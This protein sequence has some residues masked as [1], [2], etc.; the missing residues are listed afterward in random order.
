M[1]VGAFIHGV[2]SQLRWFDNAHN[3]RVSCPGVCP[4]LMD[5]FATLKTNVPAVGG[6]KFRWVQKRDSVP[7]NGKVNVAETCVKCRR[8]FNGS[9]VTYE[10]SHLKKP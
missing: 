4:E 7:L 3:L 6:R 2:L 10:K 8:C 5:W 1:G 9:A